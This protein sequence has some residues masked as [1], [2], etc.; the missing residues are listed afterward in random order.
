MKIKYLGTL[1]MALL[2]SIG[3]F[4]TTAFA[5]ADGAEVTEPTPTPAEEVVEELMEPLTPDGNMTLVD[6]TGEHPS[7]GKQFI[8]VVTKSGNYFYLII[9]RDDEGK[10]TVHFLNQVDEADLMKLMDEEELEQINLV[11]ET[12]PTST[13]KPESELDAEIE[14][15]EPE[16]EPQK[17]LNVFP[18]I[19]TVIL[20]AAGGGFYL[21]KKFKEKKLAKTQGKSD[22]DADYVEEEDYGYEE[23]DN[24]EYCD[25]QDSNKS[26]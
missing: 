6:D 13:P 15:S 4:S 7:E 9:D 17:K 20:F 18:A 24:E 3:V 11:E 12:M 26:R 14:V 23:Y 25:Q 21:W 10:E 5:Y 16:T 22:P 2:L 19:V 1:C 8:T